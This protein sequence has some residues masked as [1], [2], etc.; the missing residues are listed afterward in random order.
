MRH[1][2]TLRRYCPSKD[3]GR[4]C[5]V[6]RVRAEIHLSA[7]GISIFITFNQQIQLPRQDNQKDDRKL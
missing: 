1:H 5:E 2:K 3:D 4:R 7:N 6:F